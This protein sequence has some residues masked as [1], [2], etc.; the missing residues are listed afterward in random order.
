MYADDAALL[1]SKCMKLQIEMVQWLAGTHNRVPVFDGTF[2]SLIDFY[3]R[4]AESPYRK[5]KAS[6]LHPY[7]IYAKKVINHIGT[8]R[9]SACDGRDLSRWFTTWSAP[10]KEDG[11]KR[12]PAARMALAVLKSAITFGIGCRLAGCAEFQVVMRSVEFPTSKRRPY[13]PTAEQ[14]TA[15]RKAAHAAGA[16][17]R[18]LLY[19]L[20]FETTLRQWDVIGEWVE[21]SDPR[22]SAVL[23]YG[24]KW[25]G[26]TWANIDET[27]VLRVTPTKTEGTTDAHVAFDLKE[28]PMVMAELAGIPIEKRVGP[29]ITDQRKGLPYRYGNYLKRWRKDFAAAG[30]PKGVWNRDLRA[31]GI[32]EAGIAGAQLSDTSKVAGHSSTKTTARVYDRDT[33]EAHRRVAKARSAGRAKESDGT[34]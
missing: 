31:G 25:I 34:P 9:I 4:D 8:L 16:P 20:Q 18:A 10:V 11:P 28:C 12:I 32:T 14:V 22:P 23:G 21:I 5:L 2:G 3:Q 27:M 15:A 30:I 1:S 29:L 19:A 13:A 17:A 7:Q 24:R 26:P 33:V 6:T